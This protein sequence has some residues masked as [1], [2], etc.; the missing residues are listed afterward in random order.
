MYDALFDRSDWIASGQVLSIASELGMDQDRL[1]RCVTAEAAEKIES[2]GLVARKLGIAGTPTFLIGAL[3]ADGTVKVSTRL[4]GL[5][6]LSA[7]QEAI[8]KARTK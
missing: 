8:D 7:F 6:P 2:D 5:T 3:A 1:Q 4:S